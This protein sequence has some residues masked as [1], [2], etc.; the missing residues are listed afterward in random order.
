MLTFAAAT[1]GFWFARNRIYETVLLLL[2][3]FTLF[4]PGFWMDMISAPYD[5]Q[6]PD[7]FV[8]AIAAAPANADVRVIVAGEDDV[9][10]PREF[11]LILPVGE[12]GDG[13]AR[14]EAAGLEIL[15]EDGEVIVDGAAFDSPAAN[16]GFDFDQKV[17]KVLI[18]RDQLPKQLMYIPALV[19]LVLIA[20]MQRRRRR[21]SEPA[22]Q[23]A[24][25]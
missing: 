13:P 17:L 25:A 1:Q 20:M 16:A 12:P 6:T 11:F 24:A 21:P 19:V 9:G 10:N 2:C 3:A 4:R 5:E 22:P 15:Q 7:K 23:S 8:E 18:P 14:L